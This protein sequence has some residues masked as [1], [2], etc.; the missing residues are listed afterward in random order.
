[1]YESQRHIAVSSRLGG[2]AQA[3][4]RPTPVLSISPTG[5]RARI[6]RTG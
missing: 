5:A 3:P 2:N 4:S 1:V 6:T